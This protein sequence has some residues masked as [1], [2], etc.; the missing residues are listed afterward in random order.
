MPRCLTATML[1]AILVWILPSPATACDHHAFKSQP[2]MNS[3]S[4]VAFAEPMRSHPMVSC[5]GSCIGA[6]CCHGGVSSCSLAWNNSWAGSAALDLFGLKRGAR[7]AYG[8]EQRADYAE[9]LY[10]LDRPP[11]A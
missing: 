9:P 6:C 10:G 3:A 7:L 8:A 5:P 4:V 2:V 1:L 11:K